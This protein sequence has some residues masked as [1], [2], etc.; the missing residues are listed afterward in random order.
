MKGQWIQITPDELAFGTFVGNFRHQECLKNNSKNVAGAEEDDGERDARGAIYEMAFAKFLDFKYGLPVAK[1][2]EPDYGPY[3]VRG[4]HY[5]TG[6][7]IIRPRDIKKWPGSAW[8]LVRGKGLSYEIAGWLWVEEAQKHGEFKDPTS[9]GRGNPCW[10]IEDK[11]LYSLDE[12]PFEPI[13]RPS[14]ATTH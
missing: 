4:T 14:D 13:E 1:K 2:G 5:R 10:M 6:K 3:H 9:W 7:L 8:V 11:Y 12:L